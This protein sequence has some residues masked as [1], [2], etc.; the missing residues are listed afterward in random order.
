MNIVIERIFLGDKYTIGKLYV[1]GVYLCDTLEQPVRDIE[2]GSAVKY[3]TYQVNCVWSPK[4]RR[5]MLRVE[6]PHRCGILIHAGN[7]VNDTTGCI[8]LG[9]NKVVGRLLN[10]RKYVEILR[11][12]V[13]EAMTKL[14]TVIL[15]SVTKK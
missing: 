12:K 1:D 9:E 3:G 6:V 8:L 13:I 10:S 7:S 2:F 11:N 15:C 14:D 4:F 5:Y